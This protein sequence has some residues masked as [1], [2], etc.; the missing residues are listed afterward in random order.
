MSAA[1]FDRLLDALNGRV[2][3]T[4]EVKQAKV[5]KDVA[6]HVAAGLGIADLEPVDDGLPPLIRFAPGPG[7][8]GSKTIPR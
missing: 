2:T 8:Q 5:G 4:I 1:A 3:R 7:V 6:D